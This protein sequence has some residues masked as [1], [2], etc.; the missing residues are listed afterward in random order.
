MNDKLDNSINE[1]FWIRFANNDSVIK[2]QV[3][4]LPTNQIY[5]VSGVS[6]VQYVEREK[7]LEL[8]KMNNKVIKYEGTVNNKKLTGIDNINAI[9]ENHDSKKKMCETYQI[10]FVSSDFKETNKGLDDNY[11]EE[12][13]PD[14]VKLD[15]DKKISF[16]NTNNGSINEKFC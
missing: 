8:E 10:I 4:P 7:N 12:L 1:E 13:R 16:N 6:E 3:I 11:N 15:D 5:D 9:K 2:E 14:S